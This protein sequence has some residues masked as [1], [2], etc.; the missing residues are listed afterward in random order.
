MI[1]YDTGNGIGRQTPPHRHTRVAAAY[2]AGRSVDTLIRWQKKGLVVPSDYM[3]AG[4][5][6]V[7]LYTDDDILE[8]RK[9]ALTQRP[10]RKPNAHYTQKG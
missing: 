3:Q 5:L 8:L 10:G 7:W 1:R 2:L 4:K 6:K 9:A